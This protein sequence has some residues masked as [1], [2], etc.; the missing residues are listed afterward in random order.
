MIAD[1]WK[2]RI[3]RA[4][5]LTSCY[6]FAAEGL[7][8]YARVAAFQQSLYSEIQQNSSDS[9]KTS[10]HRPLRE[11]LDLVFLLP[12]FLGFLSL[13]RQ[14][15]PFPLAQAAASLADKREAHWARS[16]EEFWRKE[17][18][19]PADIDDNETGEPGATARRAAS[20]ES[21]SWHSIRRR[22]LHTCASMSAIRA[23]AI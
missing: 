19:W 2:R 15:A 20:K 6:P 17:A 12:K 3:H 14:I 9:L 22:K 18:A 11:E 16:L 23:T 13:I 10:A 21:R 1:Q 7:R 8:F 5:E 4:N